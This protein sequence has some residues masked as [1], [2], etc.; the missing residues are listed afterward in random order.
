MPEQGAAVDVDLRV[1]RDDIAR[2]RDDQRIDFDQA[3]IAFDEQSIHAPD[4]VG[5]LPHLPLVQAEPEAEPARLEIQQA[6]IGSDGDR[7]Y[8]LRRLC[9]DGLDVHAAGSRGDEGYPA[10][11]AVD[12]HGQ[13]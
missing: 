2:P 1:Q 8:L 7:E 5:E 10:H 13:V 4:Q 12:E 3:G 9:R 6:G 11:L